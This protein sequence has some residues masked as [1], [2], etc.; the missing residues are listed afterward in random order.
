M[1]TQAAWAAVHHL[2]PTLQQ[3]PQRVQRLETLP[4]TERRLWKSSP[5]LELN[6]VL[7]AEISS[8]ASGAATVS[9]VTATGLESLQQKVYL[10]K[11][12]TRLQIPISNLSNGLHFIRIDNGYER[13]VKKVLIEK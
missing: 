13:L 6:D 8:T 4:S 2:Q 7:Q 1:L 12:N 10:T 5:K 11:G 3:L 9:V